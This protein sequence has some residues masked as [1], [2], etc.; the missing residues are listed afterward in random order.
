MTPELVSLRSDAIEFL[1]H[2]AN[3]ADAVPQP[4]IALEEA[5]DDL[6]VRL[7]ILPTRLRSWNHR[8][9]RRHHARFDDPNLADLAFAA[10][11]IDSAV[12]SC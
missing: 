4:R 3:D 11:E 12:V 9:S 7:Q 1:T 10:G 5:V 2:R 6:R 8:L